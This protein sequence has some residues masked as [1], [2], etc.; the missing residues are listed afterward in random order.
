L[1]KKNNKE[2][3]DNYIKKWN[4]VKNIPVELIDILQK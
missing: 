4:D 2:L 1:D 3:I